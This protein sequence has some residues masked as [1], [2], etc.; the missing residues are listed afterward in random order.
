M[1]SK[2][3]KQIMG[4]PWLAVNSTVGTGLDYPNRALFDVCPYDSH[5][6]KVHERRCIP[7]AEAIVKDHNAQ[8]A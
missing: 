7:L 6:L 3:V 5:S 2:L 8:L 4:S 1:V